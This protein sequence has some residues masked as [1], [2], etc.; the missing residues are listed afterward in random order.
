MR[1]FKRLFSVLALILLTSVALASPVVVARTGYSAS[2]AVVTPRS[3]S[4]FGNPP[5]PRLYFGTVVRDTADEQSVRPDREQMPSVRLLGG[6]S[7]LPP[8][9]L[10]FVRDWA[11]LL[12]VT[13]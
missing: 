1:T 2:P 3:H 4:G 8:W 10:C 6:P 12:L 13:R 5:T 7:Y 11:S 9:V